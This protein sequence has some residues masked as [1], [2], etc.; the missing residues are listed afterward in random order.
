LKARIYLWSEG[1]DFKTFAAKNEGD[2]SSEAVLVS[3]FRN[4]G[5]DHADPVLAIFDELRATWHRLGKVIEETKRCE[6]PLVDEVQGV[7]D[8]AK[9]E[10]LETPPDDSG[11][12]SRSHRVAGRIRRAQ[13]SRNVRR[14]HA[15]ADPLADLRPRGGAL[16]NTTPDRRAVLGAGPKQAPVFIRTFPE[17]V[18]AA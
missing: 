18:D 13:H 16:M 8:V 2:G 17:V 10:L 7:L 15:D 14:I 11:R 1:T 12:R 3:L 5:V 4:L 9:A 6:G